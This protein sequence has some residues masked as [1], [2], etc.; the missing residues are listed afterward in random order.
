MYNSDLSVPIISCG[1]FQQVEL[2]VGSRMKP[3]QS[4]CPG[5]F[6]F[7]TEGDGCFHA[8]ASHGV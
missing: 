3:I 5:D 4:F 1:Y 8:I 6:L 2:N 7:V